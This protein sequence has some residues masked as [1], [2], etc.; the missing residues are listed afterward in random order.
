MLG[1]ED[2]AETRAWL[3]PFFEM[4]YL[5]AHCLVSQ[6]ATPGS[7]TEIIC[8]LGKLGEVI[9]S[10]RGGCERKS[11]TSSR[12]FYRELAKVGKR[13]EDSF[14]PLVYR[15]FLGSTLD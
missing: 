9:M 12:L 6:K 3:G 7:V 10:E 14:S 15:E 5:G 1:W 11:P 13:K 8:Y 4:R 2:G